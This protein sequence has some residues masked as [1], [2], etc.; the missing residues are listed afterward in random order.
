MPAVFFFTPFRRNVDSAFSMAW[1]A[2]GAD[3]PEFRLTFVKRRRHAFH[4]A[5][6]RL[7]R[8]MCSEFA[9]FLT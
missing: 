5:T 1:L 8:A 6:P 7:S 2:G 3:R 4:A 9:I